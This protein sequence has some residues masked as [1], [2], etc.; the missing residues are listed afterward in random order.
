MFAQHMWLCSW[1]CPPPLF[2]PSIVPSIGCV[3][4][5]ADTA[6]INSDNIGNVAEHPEGVGPINLKNNYTDPLKFVG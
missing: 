3:H 5:L 4:S 6:H 1:V 2:Y